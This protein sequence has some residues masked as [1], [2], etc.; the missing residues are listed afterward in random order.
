MHIEFLVEDSSGK[1]LLEF[2]VP[3]VLGPNGDQN[4]W[5]LI[6]YKGVGHIPSGFRGKVDASK[7]ILLDRL[8]KLLR[9]YARTPGV[10]AVVVVVDADRRDCRAF[11]EELTAVLK[12]C[13]PAPLTIFRLAIE[14]IEAWYLGDR[15]AL[16]AA[17]PKARRDVLKG[18]V[19]DSVCGTWELLADAV[20]EGGVN[21][22]RKT[23]WPLPGQIKHDWA[24]SIGPHM[25]IESNVSPSFRKF[26]KG[27]RKL[28]AV[29]GQ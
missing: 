19:Q 26:C 6:S 27:L 13:N 16:L 1:S 25:T 9:G 21:K 4:T 5:R 18:Y 12:S 17:Y 2:I 14:E 23:G 28:G 15:G 29:P 8:P 10:D 22:V 20:C 7:R 24:A 11:L 3:Q